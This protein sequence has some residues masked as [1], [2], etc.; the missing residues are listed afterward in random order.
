MDSATE[1]AFS[2]WWGTLEG[3]EAFTV[4]FKDAFAAGRSSLDDHIKVLFNS[5]AE[6]RRNGGG[7]MIKMSWIEDYIKRAMD[8]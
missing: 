2:K 6:Q 3:R 7:E 1:R 8:A 4:G 5:F